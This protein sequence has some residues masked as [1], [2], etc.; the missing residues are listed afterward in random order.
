MSISFIEKKKY[1][2]AKKKKNTYFLSIPKLDVNAYYLI[3]D[4]TQQKTFTHTL[5][6]FILK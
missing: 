4:I 3:T 1:S 6:P 5:A 2:F